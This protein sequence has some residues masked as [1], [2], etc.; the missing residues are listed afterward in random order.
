MQAELK[1][2]IGSTS[3]GAKIT[4]VIRPPLAIPPM[5][6]LPTPGQ[7]F[8]CTVDK[9]HVQTINLDPHRDDNYVTAYHATG[10]THALHIVLQGHVNVGLGQSAKYH[11]MIYFFPPDKIQNRVFYSAY[12]FLNNESPYLGLATVECIVNCNPKHGAGKNGPQ[13][14][15]PPNPVTLTAV[16][17]HCIHVKEVLH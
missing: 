6:S 3:D 13:L 15:K 8:Q 11:G 4:S 12:A 7:W 17:F 9:S 2:Y 14:V 10:V 16:Y 5:C 1:A